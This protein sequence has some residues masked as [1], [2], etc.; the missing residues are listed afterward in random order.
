[1][2]RVKSATGSCGSHSLFLHSHAQM[3]VPVLENIY[4]KVFCSMV[5]SSVPPAIR[6]RSRQGAH[7]SYPLAYFTEKGI[8]GCIRVGDGPEQHVEGI[9]ASPCQPATSHALCK[10]KS[11]EAKKGLPWR[12]IDN[13]HSTSSAVQYQMELKRTSTTLP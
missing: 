4:L 10:Y 9:T 6:T 13:C 12:R 3:M 8:R 7:K 5:S 2:H 11:S 1:M